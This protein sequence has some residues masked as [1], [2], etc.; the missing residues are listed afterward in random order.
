MRR[1]LN[2]CAFSRYPRYLPSAPPERGCSPIILFENTKIW[3]RR[4]DHHADW[5]LRVEL[6]RMAADLAQQ[7]V[8]TGD[9]VRGK[10]DA[11]WFFTRDMQVNFASPRV[12]VV[13]ATMRGSPKQGH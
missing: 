3:L 10:L 12:I 11:S 2:C 13:Y 7:L 5:R 6:G 1:T 9:I 8:K 4:H